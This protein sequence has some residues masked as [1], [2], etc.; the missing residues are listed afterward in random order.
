VWNGSKSNRFERL[1][2]TNVAKS[3][4]DDE[5]GGR[6]KVVQQSSNPTAV[7]CSEMAT[8]VIPLQVTICV[9][10]SKF[11]GA[12]RIFAQIFPNSTRKL[13]CNFC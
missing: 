3:I 10:A 9:G 11:L 8:S 2:A 5:R 4:R 7:K 12:Q 6:G 13:S 1:Q